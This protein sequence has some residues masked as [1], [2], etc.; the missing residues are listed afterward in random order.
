MVSLWKRFVMTNRSLCKEPVA[1]IGVYDPG[2]PCRRFLIV[3]FGPATHARPHA[4]SCS[5]HGEKLH[6]YMRNHRRAARRS[7]VRRRREEE[8]KREP[9]R[10]VEE[11]KLPFPWTR[12]WT[13]R[14]LRSARLSFFSPP[15]SFFY[16]NEQNWRTCALVSADNKVHLC[17]QWLLSGGTAGW[18]L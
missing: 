4:S 7:L 5:A 2:A 18:A 16:D 12:K 6:F 9:K 15:P 14:S 8:R 13:S 11:T 17:N 3:N 10:V 1:G